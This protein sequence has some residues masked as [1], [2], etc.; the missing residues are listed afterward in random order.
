MA[1][2]KRT[3]TALAAGQGFEI[4]VE[5]L[6]A[7]RG[8]GDGHADGAAGFEASGIVDVAGGVSREKPWC[9]FPEQ[10]VVI[11]AGR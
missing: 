7:L 2:Q 4:E 6:G 9:A 3:A 10:A 5:I 8:H 1:A 11:R